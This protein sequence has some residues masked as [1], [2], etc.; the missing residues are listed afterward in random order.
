MS[1]KKTVSIFRSIKANS[2]TLTI[3]E[4]DTWKNNVSTGS[5]LSLRIFDTFRKITHILRSSNF[6]KGWSESNVCLDGLRRNWLLYYPTTRNS[7][8]SGLPSMTSDHNYGYN[9]RII[10]NNSLLIK[11]VESLLIKGLP[12]FSLSRHIKLKVFNYEEIILGTLSQMNIS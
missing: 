1:Q 12:V 11:K 7:D 10:V 2:C 3:E 5:K 9:K 8:T 6:K 4:M